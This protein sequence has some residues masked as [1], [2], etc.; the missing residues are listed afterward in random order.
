VSATVT[1]QEHSLQLARVIPRRSE[2]SV[3]IIC[4]TSEFRLERR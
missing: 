1:R 4:F 3:R 2:V